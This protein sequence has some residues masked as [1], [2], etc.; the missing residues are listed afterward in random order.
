MG[1]INEETGKR[2]RHARVA[3]KMSCP[4]LAKKVGLSA[5]IIYQLETGKRCLK[6][7]EAEK[8]A[9]ILGV[10]A[11]WIAQGVFPR[12]PAA[13]N[14]TAHHDRGEAGPELV[15]STP[16]AG[17]TPAP[18]EPTMPG[19]A[20]EPATSLAASLAPVLAESPKPAPPEGNAAPTPP[21]STV[22]GRAEGPSVPLAV[23]LESVP[24]EA[25]KIAKPEASPEPAP[26]DDHQPTPPKD[27]K[28]TLRRILTGVLPPFI[29]TLLRSERRRLRTW[30]TCFC[31]CGVVFLL[32]PVV[33]LRWH[34][35]GVA[36]CGFFVLQMSL[37]LSALDMEA[38]RARP[39]DARGSA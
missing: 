22:P 26:A 39:H 10:T 20:E 30:I 24:V 6:A 3:A 9:E 19:K 14:G 18:P 15:A 38:R 28:A 23:N 12:I 2:L 33:P 35:L 32:Y 7:N 29:V 36:V 11:S 8:M 31:L 25:P 1:T 17:S 34:A 13:G 27:V 21:Q 5:D 4:A 37:R 16:A